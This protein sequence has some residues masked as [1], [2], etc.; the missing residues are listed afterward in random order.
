[1]LSNGK[2]KGLNTNKQ[3]PPTT[4]TFSFPTSETELQYSALKLMPCILIGLERIN[5]EQIILFR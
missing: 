3:P 4:K 1:M 5:E 2:R